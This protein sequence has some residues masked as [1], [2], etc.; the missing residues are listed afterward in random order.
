MNPVMSL[1]GNLLI[2]LGLF[3][4]ARLS[5]LKDNEEPNPLS[6]IIWTLSMVIGMPESRL[7]SG[8]VILTQ[9]VQAMI[10]LLCMLIT[11]MSLGKFFNCRFMLFEK[12]EKTEKAVFLAFTILI[13]TILCANVINDISL[14]KY[15]RFFLPI[16]LVLG[17]I[18]MVKEVGISTKQY[19]LS[20]WLVMALG[21]SILTIASMLNGLGTD[22][23]LFSV[24]ML[25]FLSIPVW[26][27]F[28]TISGIDA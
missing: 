24:C 2:L 22:A 1:V 3:L 14:M 7:E 27:M 4:Y 13:W 19:R 26:Y 21:Y 9:F 17:A 15:A 18:P 16:G 28:T 6:W 12:T 23:L 11:G 20:P 25:T 5:I 8:F 10:I